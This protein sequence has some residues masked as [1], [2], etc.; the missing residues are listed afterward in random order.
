MELRFAKWEVSVTPYSTCMELDTNGLGRMASKAKTK[1]SRRRMRARWQ[2]MPVRDKNRLLEEDGGIHR[3][4][5]ETGKPG[6]G[7]V[8]KEEDRMTEHM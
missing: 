6:W 5:W 1:V 8:H 7:I 2:S 3:D 4:I